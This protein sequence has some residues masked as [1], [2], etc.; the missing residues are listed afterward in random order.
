LA[1]KDNKLESWENNNKRIAVKVGSNVVTQPDGSLNSWRISR[2]V[3]DI[4]VLFRQGKEVILITSGA[5]AAGRGEVN[6]TRKTSLV[7]SR[8]VLSAVG[9]VKLMA[10]YQFLF[11]KYGIPAGQVLTTKESFGDRMHY[12]NMKN[13]I[14]AMLDNKVI[15]IV[16]ENDTIAIDEL[17][18]TDNDEL[19]GLISSMMDCDLLIILTNVDGIYNGI[20]GDEGV[21]LIQEI[22]EDSVSLDQYISSSVSGSGRGGMLTKY[23]NAR[24]AALEGADVYIANGLRDSVILD[25]IRKKDI[26]FTRFVA[27]RNKKTG[28]KKWIT[29]SDSFVKGAVRIND[30][31]RNALL[32]KKASS[33][34]F[35]GITGIDGVFH[36]GD[37]VRILDSNGNII[38]IGKSQFDSDEA[39]LHLGEK[40]NKPLIHYDYLVINDKDASN[41]SIKILT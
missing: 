19:S 7:T 10:S 20:P 28:I 39:E 37:L 36:K 16:N 13:C 21:D 26:P 38:G 34:L 12:L 17:M 5:V 41:Y 23:T 9:Q 30:G 1:S 8:Q 31:A 2:L 27:A 33:L 11:G 35:I 14:S 25:I 22:S 3:E 4:A 6:P 40:Y 29:H 18:F 15:P 24:K 32:G